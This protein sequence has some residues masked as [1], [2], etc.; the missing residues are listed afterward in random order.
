LPL[1]ETVALG[2]GLPLAMVRVPAAAPAAAG[3]KVTLTVQL[4]AGA[5]MAPQVVVSAN[6]P[7]MVTLAMDMTE[8]LVFA[9]LT[10]WAALVVLT[11]C[12]VKVSAAGVMVSPPKGRL[13]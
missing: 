11:S 12:G 3:V 8:M 9:T 2:V 5:R 4:A 1:R 6:G 10:I 13:P 7:E